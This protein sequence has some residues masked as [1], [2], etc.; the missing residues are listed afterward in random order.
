LQDFSAKKRCHHLFHPFH[1][2]PVLSIRAA[3]EPD[4]DAS[5]LANRPAGT[6]QTNEG[7]IIAGASHGGFS[8]PNEVIAVGF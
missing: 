8:I 6:V 4:A 3:D 5:R 1:M 7:F 2:N